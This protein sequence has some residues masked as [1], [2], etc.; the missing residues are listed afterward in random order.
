M[1]GLVVKTYGRFYTIKHEER[2]INCVLRGK[3]KQDDNLNIYSEPIV[4]GDLVE[5]SFNQDET[6]VIEK[7]LERKNIF[8]RKD[9]NHAK[10]DPI[11]ANIDQ[12]LIIQ[13]FKTP[14]LNLRFV[15]RLLVRAE[16][17]EI[18]AIICLNKVDLAKSKDLEYVK[19]YYQGSGYQILLV[20]AKSG[21]GLA[22]L[23]KILEEKISLLVGHS[24]VGKTSLL[25]H[26]CPDLNLPVS[27]VSSGSNKGK[28]TTTNAELIN[29][30]GDTHII[31]TPGLREFGLMDIEPQDLKNYFNEFREYNDQCNFQSCTHDHEPKCAVKSQVEQKNI[32]E[33]RYI[34]YLN[35]LHSL[36]DY[37]NNLY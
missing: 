16:K 31:D 20:S 19:Q 32:F 11:A 12:V 3:I 35:I 15:D 26:F 28:H 5:F 8:T 24:G 6:G 4:A 34:S 33:D 29:L 9:K 25:N 7:I 14:K 37:Y 2:K 1:I 22:D 23:K 27:E 21:Q 36:Q 17:E 13:S 10:E 30:E 18:P